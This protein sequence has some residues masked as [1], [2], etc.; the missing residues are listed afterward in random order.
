MIYIEK[1]DRH[2]I[3]SET[4]SKIYF[5]K[6]NKKINFYI[7]PKP[8]FR[9]VSDKKLIS[10]F[11]EIVRIIWQ[12]LSIIFYLKLKKNKLVILREFNSLIILLLILLPKKFKS[13][14]ILFINHNITTPN[15]L[16]KNLIFNNKTT[17]LKF[18]I[19]DGLKIKHLFNY[20]KNI[21][22]PLFPINIQKELITKTINLLKSKLKNEYSVGI[23]LSLNKKSHSRISE[24]K[25]SLIS[26]LLKKNINLKIFSRES[27]IISKLLPRNKLLKVINT[28]TKEKYI[29]AISE[30]TL[31]LI[32]DSSV[33]SSYKYRHSGSIMELI[34]H[35]CIPIIPN[36]TL[37]NSQVNNPCETGFVYQ[38]NSDIDALAKTIINKIKLLELNQ[39]KYI[40]NLERYLTERSKNI[41]I[42]L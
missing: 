28:N 27:K 6:N 25:L 4:L 10:F 18:L 37:L 29:E 32:Y 31:F 1:E 12:F 20:P 13:K 15:S 8:I 41:L 2:K 16:I 19:Y 14:I 42:N 21:Y 7:I 34:T 5:Y 23:S 39:E 33:E 24:K 38:I 26:K 30:T 9:I 3:I 17:G 36:L 11:I 40:D 22:T 35:G